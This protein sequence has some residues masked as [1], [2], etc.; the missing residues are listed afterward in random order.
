MFQIKATDH[1]SPTR[2]SK[3]RLDVEWL[4]QPE[5]SSEPLAFDEAHFTFAVME[6]DP[7]THMVGIISTEITPSLLWFDIVGEYTDNILSSISLCLSNHKQDN[8][9]RTQY[10]VC[11]DIILCLWQL[12]DLAK[13]KQMTML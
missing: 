9:A 2:M 7:V 10:T 13:L 4:P 6:S 5:P 11:V 3:T 1:G 8:L 12:P